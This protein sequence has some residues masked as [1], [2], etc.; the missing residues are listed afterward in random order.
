M[1]FSAFKN[2]LLFLFIHSSPFSLLIATLINLEEKAQD[3]V[4]ETKKI[5]IPGY[6]HAFNAGIIEWQGSLLMSFRIIPNPLS[7]FESNIGLVWLDEDFRPIG[8]PQILNLRE[9][10]LVPSRAEDARLV[11]IG[12]RLYMVYSDN[13]EPKISKGGFRVYIAELEYERTHFLVKN[14]ECLSYFEGES[15]QI[16]EKNWVPFEYQK[17]LLLA[18]SLTPHQI[19][20]PLLKGTG[21]CETLFTT[22]PL[23]HWEWGDLRGGTP[24]L[25]VDASHYLSFFH[26]SIYL[27]TLHSNGK[28][29]THYFI[30]AYL[31]SSD[32]PFTI[33][34]VS[35]EPII[36]KSFY[37][38]EIYKP[39]WK[40]VRAIFPCGFI[41]DDHYIWIAYGRQDHEVWIVKL[42]KQ[43]LLNSLIPVFPYS[44]D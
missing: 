32:P 22:Q 37:Q 1:T 10:S 19:F 15:Q 33:T 35:P 2:F 6:P 28:N 34:D 12:K 9:H 31:F 27:S 38:G 26:S 39:Y 42:D 21:V 5:E 40:P 44:R 3:F 41:M 30:G 29:I 43:G 24:A 17:N 36:G 16:R 8:K 23:I 14:F 7:S 11:T 25:M 20:R 18:Y 13:M 4:L